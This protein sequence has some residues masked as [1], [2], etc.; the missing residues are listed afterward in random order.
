MKAT[1]E[2]KD[3]ERN[4][5]ML[6]INAS[7]LYSALVSASEQIRTALKHGSDKYKWSDDEYTLLLEIQETIDSAIY[8]AGIN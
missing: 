5:L 6:A 7:S 3:E 4:E 2:Y 8:E 1:L